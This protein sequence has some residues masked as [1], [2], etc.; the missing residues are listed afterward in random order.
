M[1]YSYIQ[2]LRN[3]MFIATLTLNS[4]AIQAQVPGMTN[5][6]SHGGN[7]I[8]LKQP[9]ST[10]LEALPLGNGTLG[11]MV[12]GQPEKERIQ[13]NE[14]SLVTGTPDLVG[15][16]QPFGNIIFDFA[17]E[18]ASDYKRSLE[19]SNAIHTITYQHN[20]IR[21]KR[22]YFVSQPDQALIMMITADKKSAVNM[23]IALKD[24]RPS[25]TAITSNSISFRGK[26]Q[27]NGMEY[28]AKAIVNAKEENASTRTVQ[29]LSPM[30]ILYWYT[31]QPLPLSK[32]S[33]R[34][35]Y[36]VSYPLICSMQDWALF[37]SN[38]TQS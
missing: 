11:A 4:I 21:F 1:K 7:E 10:W 8:W 15:F 22:E 2:S 12:Y 30:Q 28:M 37:L 31:C 5:P 25:Q 24:A 34:E 18:N 33:M 36:M 17:H 13:F 23:A 19:L 14:N 29:L 35:M 20:S 27:E 26:L 32:N 16:Y 38:P 3:V 9:A 6:Q